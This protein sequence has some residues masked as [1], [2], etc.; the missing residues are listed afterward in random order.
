ALTL[1]P[2]L[3]LAREDLK[4]KQFNLLAQQNFLLPDLR[5][6]SSY[7]ITGLGSKLYGDGQFLDSTNTFR[8]DNSLRS[9]ASN[10]F[11]DWNVGLTLNVPLGYRLEYSLV[12]QAKLQLAQSYAL[13]KEQELKARNFLAKE[14]RQMQEYHKTVE[15]RRQA[16][17]AFAEEVEARFR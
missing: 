13:L 5:F 8:P 11:N 4:I 2:E 9:L 17:Q 6:T 15:A 7:A 10:H 16:R 12:R 3:V 14:F 1:R